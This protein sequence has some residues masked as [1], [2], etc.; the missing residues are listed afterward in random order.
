MESASL[1]GVLL[2]KSSHTASMACC[3]RRSEMTLI[4][5]YSI[6]KDI[7]LEDFMKIKQMVKEELF[8]SIA[9]HEIEMDR[10]YSFVFKDDSYMTFDPY[11]AEE[12]PNIEQRKMAV[13]FEPIPQVRM[14]YKAPEELHL[15]PSKSL[16][17][18]LKNCWSYLRDD[19]EGH[20]EQEK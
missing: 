12:F 9:K 14:V 10:P 19:S 6:A 16:W 13:N 20:Y 1:R 3:I 17:T 8:A 2:L 18:K 5:R 7:S 11:G 15:R 4:K